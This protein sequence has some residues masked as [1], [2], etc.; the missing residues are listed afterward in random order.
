[1]LGIL[2]TY[3]EMRYSAPSVKENQSLREDCVLDGMLWESQMLRFANRTA[4][5]PFLTILRTR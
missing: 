1:M 5:E 2:S 3:L 4:R